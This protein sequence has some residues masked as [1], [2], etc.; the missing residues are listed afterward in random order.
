MSAPPPPARLFA[1][2]PACLQ[3]DSIDSSDPSTHLFCT[4]AFRVLFLCYRAASHSQYEYFYGSFVSMQDVYG[5]IAKYDL[6]ITAPRW[7]LMSACS[8]LI[9]QGLK[10]GV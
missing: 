1:C 10:V 3:T 6:K 7:V 2:V 4:A 8:K 9:V 5:A